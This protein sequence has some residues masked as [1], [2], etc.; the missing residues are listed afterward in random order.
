MCANR[1]PLG[2]NFHSEPK[3]HIPRKSNNQDGK[4]QQHLLEDYTRQVLKGAVY[5]VHDRAECTEAPVNGT[6]PNST[7]RPM[8]V[9]L[10]PG[11]VTSVI[12]R[13]TLG[14]HQHSLEKVHYTTCI[15]GRQ[16]DVLFQVST[17]FFYERAPGHNYLH[18]IRL[19]VVAS[20][21]YD[22]ILGQDFLRAVVSLHMWRMPDYESTLVKQQRLLLVPTPSTGAT[23]KQEQSQCSPEDHSS[24]HHQADSVQERSNTPRPFNLAV[25]A[26]RERRPSREAETKEETLDSRPTTTTEVKKEEDDLDGRACTICPCDCNLTNDAGSEWH[27]CVCSC[28]KENAPRQE[29][30]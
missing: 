20:L 17:R 18:D 4:N 19:D 14:K 25:G 11:L 1:S 21:Q 12:S 3:L 22:I 29:Q 7:G 9:L 2:C 26:E 13:S 16:R 8:A 15:Q 10:A 28:Q 23:V 6:F 30:D 5:I 27:F 24:L